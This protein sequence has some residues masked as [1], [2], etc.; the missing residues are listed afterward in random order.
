MILF[1]AML[2]SGKGKP[3]DI[4]AL[5]ISALLAVLLCILQ[6]KHIFELSDPRSADTLFFRYH[7]EQCAVIH[8]DG[9]IFI[10]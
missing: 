9:G 4:R 2:Y 1:A 8:R 10:I 7:D 5:V 3:S 6:V